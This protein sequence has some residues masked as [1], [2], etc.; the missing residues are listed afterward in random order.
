MSGMCGS[1]YGGSGGGGGPGGGVS[2][3]TFGNYEISTTTTTRYLDPGFNGNLAPVSATSWRCPADGNIEALFVSH[4]DLGAAA[5]PVV[6]TV[7]VNGVA[8]SVSCTVNAN[9][10]SGSDVANT[11]AV[12]QGQLVTVRVTKAGTLTTAPTRITA[13]F[14]VT[15]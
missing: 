1:G 13:T 8:T 14:Q 7:M 2:V 5:E 12:L 6:Y 4:T 9:A 10:A 15:S 3:V 11:A